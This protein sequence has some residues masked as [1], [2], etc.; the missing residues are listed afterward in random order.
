MNA[1]QTLLK[2]QIAEATATAANAQKKLWDLV[3]SCEDH[4][5][6]PLTEQEQADEGLSITARCEICNHDFGW[7]CLK[8]PDGV[9]HYICEND[10]GIILLDGSKIML[11]REQREMYSEC[12]VFCGQPDERK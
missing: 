12:C 2:Q 7:R 6:R 8:S 11:T 1:A 5:L 4:S 10:H 9:C 3:R